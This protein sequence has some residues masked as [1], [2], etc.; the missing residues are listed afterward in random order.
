MDKDLA[1]GAL[2]PEAKYDLSFSGGALQASVSYK[3]SAA[4]VNVQLSIPVTDLLEALKAKIPGQV[5]DAVIDVI[6]AALKS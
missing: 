5:D 4:G 6:E 3:G 2:G 1:S